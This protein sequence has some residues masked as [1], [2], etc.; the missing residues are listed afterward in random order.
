MRSDEVNPNR[1][2]GFDPDDEERPVRKRASKRDETPS[3]KPPSAPLVAQEKAKK[4]DEKLENFLDTPFCPYRRV[5]KGAAFCSISTD[6]SVSEVDPLTC[7]N[8]VV[9]EIIKVPRCRFLSLGTEIKPYRGEGRLVVS[10]A[11]RELNIKL[12]NFKTCELC[13]YVSEIP[14]IYEEAKREETVAEINFPIHKE[15]IEKA[16]RDLKDDYL[17]LLSPESRGLSNIR[18]WRFP[19][20]YCHK[21]PEYT[22]TK[23]TIVLPRTSKNDALF[24]DHIAPTIKSLNLIAYR[25]DE[26]LNDLD[27]MCRVCENIQESDYALFLID[28]WSSYTLFLIGLTYGLG[29]RIALLKRRDMNQLPLWE[30]IEGDILLYDAHHEIDQILR[31]H[32]S[33]Y[34]GRN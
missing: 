28:D 27:A 20:G 12:F 16:V 25:V 34:I 30:F 31:E 13:P 9:P 8:C 24:K 23:V 4:P 2:P 19:D 7:F 5:S 6:P 22:R 33:H 18:C 14:S 17:R 15:L 26:E 1:D 21:L 10:M 32:F 11:C 3:V 29:K